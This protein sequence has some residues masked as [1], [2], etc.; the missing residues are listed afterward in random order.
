MRPRKEQNPS[1]IYSHQQHLNVAIGMSTVP[2]FTKFHVNSLSI[3][4][5]VAQWVTRLTCDWWIP[6]N[7]EFERHQKSLVVTLIAQYWLVP[8]TDSS[9][10]YISKI[11]F[12]N[13][14]KINEY[15][16]S[17]VGK[18]SYSRKLITYHVFRCFFHRQRTHVVEEMIF[19]HETVFEYFSIDLP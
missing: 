12:H 15:K 10:F 1:A 18:V 13:Q 14:T 19:G 11:L 4:G 17:N 5:G 16:L 7:R 8:G 2:L 6:V 3:I 9:V